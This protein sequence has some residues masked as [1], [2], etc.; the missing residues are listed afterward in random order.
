MLR[1]HIG[2]SDLGFL[3]KNHRVPA[4][5]LIVIYYPLSDRN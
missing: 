5:C 4:S 3:R 1:E 2:R